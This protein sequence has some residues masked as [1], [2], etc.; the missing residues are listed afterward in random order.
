MHRVFS[1]LDSYVVVHVYDVAV[2]VR[3]LN[4]DRLDFRICNL[5][6]GSVQYYCMR[7]SG[8]GRLNSDRLDFR[9]RNLRHGS[10]EYYACIILAVLGGLG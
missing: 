5:R 3:T 7:I 2:L 4:S 6:H 10:V 8:A 1:A 9:I